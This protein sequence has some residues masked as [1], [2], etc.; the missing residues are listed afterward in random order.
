MVVLDLGV[1]MSYF[2]VL[3]PITSIN[4]LDEGSEV[5]EVVGFAYVGNLTFDSGGKSIVELS[6][7]CGIAPLDSSCKAVE[8]DEVFGDTFVVM[9]LEVFDFC[10][11]FPFRVMGSEVRLELGDEFIVVIEPIGCQV[12]E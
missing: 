11:S 5:G 8:F 12:G 1:F 4:G 10:F 9:H 7:E 6:S 2:G 3:F